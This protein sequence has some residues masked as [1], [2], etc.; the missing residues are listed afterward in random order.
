[1][2][3]LEKLTTELIKNSN[4]I[5]GKISTSIDG[6]KYQYITY[7]LK[8]PHAANWLVKLFENAVK[9]VTGK[10]YLTQFHYGNDSYSF[11][12][13]PFKGGLN[14]KIQFKKLIEF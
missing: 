5:E 12:R 6:V 9:E 2:T 14:G 13:N 1:M 3:A 8:Y 10:N 7:V 4:V 11:D